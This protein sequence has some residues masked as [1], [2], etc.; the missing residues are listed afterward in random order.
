MFFILHFYNFG[1]LETISSGQRFQKRDVCSS[2]WDSC[3]RRNLHRKPDSE[4]IHSLWTAGVEKTC[5]GL[6][7]QIDRASL[8]VPLFINT[9]WPILEKEAGT[10]WGA[11]Y[12]GAQY[13][14]IIVVYF[15]CEN[16]YLVFEKW[17]FVLP[18]KYANFHRDYYPSC[19]TSCNE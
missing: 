11:F 18:L 3:L 4:L 2:V 14:L 19:V 17:F 12:F 1:K 16:I 5:S 10:W 15:F 13:V 7:L 6:L 9:K 8:Y